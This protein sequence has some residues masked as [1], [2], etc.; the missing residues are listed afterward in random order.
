MLTMANVAV[1][2][3]E[4]L[5]AFPGCPNGSLP[6]PFSLVSFPRTRTMPGWA[7]SPGHPPPD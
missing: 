6:R 2:V 7:E 3:E 5:L 1:D 4:F